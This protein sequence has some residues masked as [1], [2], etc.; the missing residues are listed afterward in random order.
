M[1]EIKENYMYVATNKLKFNIQCPVC[2][3]NFEQILTKINIICPYCRAKKEIDVL[4]NKNLAQMPVFFP[5]GL[6]IKKLSENEEVIIH[7]NE[8]NF[9]KAQYIIEI[10]EKLFGNFIEITKPRYLEKKE[11]GKKIFVYEMKISFSDV[12]KYYKGKE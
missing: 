10:L 1:K 11:K 9:P 4:D 3:K 6:L 2:D 8:F 12:Y 7:T 5:L